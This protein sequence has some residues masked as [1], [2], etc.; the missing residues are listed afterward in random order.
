MASATGE[1]GSTLWEADPIPFWDW[2]TETRVSV[3]TIQN[4]VLLFLGKAREKKNSRGVS[5]HH[6]IL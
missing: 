1:S 5:Y 6:T 3:K 2:T 4:S